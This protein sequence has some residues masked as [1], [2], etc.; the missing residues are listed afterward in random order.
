MGVAGLMT[1]PPN[2]GRR[3]LRATDTTT[4]NARE[5]KA[6]TSSAAAP[7]RRLMGTGWGAPALAWPSHVWG[8]RRWFEVRGRLSGG[9]QRG[10]KRV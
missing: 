1:P 7:R 10:L 4:S 3:T 6:S 2:L 8:W 5:G 9:K